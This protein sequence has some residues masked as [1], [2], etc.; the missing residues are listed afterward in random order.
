MM[1]TLVLSS[2]KIGN[3][4]GVKDPIPRDFRAGVVYKF[5]CAGYSVCYQPRSQGLFRGLGV[6]REKAPFPTPPPSLLNEVGLLFPALYALMTVLA[7]KI[8]LYSYSMAKT[9]KTYT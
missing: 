5:L 1:I 2:F 8:T 6:G 7:S 9:G 3:T 4:F